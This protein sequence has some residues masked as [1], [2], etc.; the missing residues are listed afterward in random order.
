MVNRWSVV[1]PSN[2]PER[3]RAFVAEWS[4][5]FT[6]YDADLIVVDDS[7]PWEDIPEFVP[8][9]TDMIRSWGF[10]EA[11]RRGACFILSLDDDVSPIGDI[12]AAYEAGFADQF[13][14]V[15]YLSVGALTNSALQMRGFPYRSREAP[16]GFQYGGWD[17]VLDYDA[18][19]QIVHNPPAA[20]FRRIR[21]P[22]PLG[23]ATT[24]CAMN[25]A[26][27]AELT[28]LAWQL[29]LHDGRYNRTGDIWSGLFQKR[30][31]DALGLVMLINGEA[32]VRHERASDPARN[33]AHEVRGLSLNDDLW[34]SLKTP[35]VA[36]G[37]SR[38]AQIAAVYRAVTDSAAVFFGRTDAAYARE[39]RRGRDLWLELF[40]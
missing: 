25:F 23:C 38:A 17:H 21:V 16:V 31:L 5:L 26:F 13:P 28:P 19:T 4:E 15:P 30:S 22:V 6:A 2:R 11:W 8:R 32:C 29:T 9:H 14:L 39:F 36:D 12:F 10:Y 27:R 18:A 37:N 20:Q 40:D 3:L 1:V 24:C 35:P 34:P 33:L 7:P